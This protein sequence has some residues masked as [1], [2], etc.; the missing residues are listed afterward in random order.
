MNHA[1]A[2]IQN[3]ATTHVLSLNPFKAVNEQLIY[4]SQKELVIY[5]FYM[6]LLAPLFVFLI[7]WHYLMRT[8]RLMAKG[9]QAQGLVVGFKP[10]STSPWAT[11]QAPIVEFTT[12]AG[13]LITFTSKIY[14]YP[15]SYQLHQQVTVWYRVD[16]PQEV[17]LDI[18]N[19]LQITCMITGTVFIVWIMA[20]L[21]LTLA[22]LT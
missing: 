14:R 3:E 10:F 11:T 7:V 15:S 5:V 6:L 8:R 9:H 17:T 18:R 21:W 1:F 16:D 19:E 13:Q 12:S 2:S 4:I 20:C 22:W